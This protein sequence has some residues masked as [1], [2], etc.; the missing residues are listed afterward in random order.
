MKYL[1][2]QEHDE[3][4]CQEGE[5]VLE[6]EG[7]EGVEE[8]GG[9]DHGGDQ[10]DV[11]AAGHHPPDHAVRLQLPDAHGELVGGADPDEVE[12]CQD[13]GEAEGEAPADHDAE[14]GQRQ[15]RHHRQ[16][17]R[18]HLVFDV[19]GTLINHVEFPIFFGGKAFEN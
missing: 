3:K 5:V 9:D 11:D 4:C 7:G 6:V 10:E 17:D 16:Q 13:P 1:K 8:G 14:V 18:A 2:Q 12:V 15:H 19:G